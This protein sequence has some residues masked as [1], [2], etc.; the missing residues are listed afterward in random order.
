MSEL[1]PSV[2]SEPTRLTV[3]QYFGLV[4]AGALTEEDRVELLE[5][6]VVAMP[7]SD[8]PHASAVTRVSAALFEAVGRRAVVRTQCAFVA[9]RS[10][11]EPDVAVVPGSFADYDTTHP[12]SAFLVVEVADSSLPQDRISK[13]RIY[14]AAGVPEYWI[15]NLRDGVVEVMREPEAAAAR[16]RERRITARGEQ[17]ELAALPDA[18]VAVSELLP[19]H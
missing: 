15:V 17:I 8:P 3:E 14:A 16:Y 6:V 11:P 10:V 1:T 9:G 12:R 7:P 13:G 19:G 4:E 2:P 5:G 18:A